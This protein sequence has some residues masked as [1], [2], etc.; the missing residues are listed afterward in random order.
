MIEC[1]QEIP[2]INL[3]LH[4]DEFRADTCPHTPDLLREF[5]CI[6]EIGD[7]IVRTF[8]CSCG[9]II[10]EYYSLRERIAT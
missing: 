2:C 8:R 4:N 3:E 1:D 10:S 5:L 7:E 6:E 9:K